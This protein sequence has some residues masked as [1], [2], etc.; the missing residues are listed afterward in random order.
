MWGCLFEALCFDFLEQVKDSQPK[1]I[2][3][4]FQSIDRRVRIAILNPAEIRL[5]EAALLP[6]LHLA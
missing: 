6:K 1:C 2:G 4:D 5:I 3:D